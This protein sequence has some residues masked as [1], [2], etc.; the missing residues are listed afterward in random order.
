GDTTPL[1]ANKVATRLVVLPNPVSFSPNSSVTVSPGSIALLVGAQFS[2]TTEVEFG[3][4]VAL[5]FTTTVKLFVALK[6]CWAGGADALKSV[7][8]VVN[9]FVLKSGASVGARGIPRLV[10]IVAFP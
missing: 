6:C 5:L 9:T 10:R 4:T 2:W 8:T 7:T 1:A 3:T